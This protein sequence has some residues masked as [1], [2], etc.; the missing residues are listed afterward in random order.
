M[1]FSEGKVGVCASVIPIKKSFL[2]VSANNARLCHDVMASFI[3]NNLGFKGQEQDQ[4]PPD[5][6]VKAEQALEALDACTENIMDSF[7]AWFPAAEEYCN[8]ISAFGF[9]K[10]KQLAVSTK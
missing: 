1:L 7:K 5:A 3:I 4:K 2:L 6:A 8:L 9:D 10:A